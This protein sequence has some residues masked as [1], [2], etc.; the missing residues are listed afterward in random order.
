MLKQSIAETL[1]VT[2]VPLNLWCNRRSDR[3]FLSYYEVHQSETD[4]WKRKNWKVG[5]WIY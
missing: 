1:T 5:I 2:K 3:S 4:Y